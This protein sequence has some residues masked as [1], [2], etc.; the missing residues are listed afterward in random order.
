VSEDASDAGDDLSWLT[1]RRSTY[2]LTRF[3]ILRGL[4]LIYLVAF[5]I[6]A[7]QLE[8]LIGSDGLLPAQ[9]YLDELA[10]SGS[11]LDAFF[12]APTIFWIDASNATL[13]VFAWIGVALASVQLIGFGNAPLSFALWALYLSFRSIGQVFWGYGWEILLL[14]AGFLACFLAP[15]IDPRPFAP[16]PSSAPVI[17]LYRWLVFR[18][19]FGA[20]L[21]KLRGDPCWVELRCLD[22]H[23]ETQPNPS[24][25]SPFFHSLPPAIHTL[26]VGFNHFVELLVPFALFGPRRL[27]HLAGALMIAF[28]LV[29]IASGNLSFL[30]WLT[31]VVAL[32][33]FDDTLLERFVPARIRARVREEVAP[34]RLRGLAIWALVLV[35]VLLSVA[36]TVNLFS[37]SQQMN[38]SFD[39]F[40]LVNTYGAFGSVGR[41][42]YQVVIEGTSADVPDD[43]AEWR[44]Y[45]LPC[46]PGPLDRAPCLVTPYHHRLD[47]QMWF[48]A[49]QDYQAE[50][51]IVH[52]VHKLL[53]GDATVKR[54]F[55]VDPF[56]SEPPKYVRAILYRYE[57][58]PAPGRWWK[59]ERLALYLR[60]MA[61]DDPEMLAFLR[62]YGWVDEG[63]R[64]M[65]PSL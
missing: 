52:L 15:P 34:S 60:P 19:M 28:Q 43:A 37:P 26:G 23:Y 45:V 5:L 51:W 58:D 3:A 6:A 12:A 62:A 35:V 57:F 44:E 25:L 17:W 9:L 14:E 65:E 55:V 31:I 49:L 1:R 41:E 50:P 4:G 59:R 11:T 2:E 10:R 20:G 54:F 27:R 21:I 47:W 33:A 63:S 30:N 64:T 36:P 46:N 22:F 8:P 56:P 24:P 39:P 38:A 40:H 48:A 13:L 32:S 53:I 29:L 42:R 18:L 16:S 7:F 61:K